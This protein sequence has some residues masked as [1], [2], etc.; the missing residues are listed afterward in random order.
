MGTR[1]QLFFLLFIIIRIKAIFSFHVLNK[2]LH[3]IK[4]FETYGLS[5]GMHICAVKFIKR[6]VIK[7]TFFSNNFLSVYLFFK[8]DLTYFISIRFQI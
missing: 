8:F 3:S 6:L 7:L 4:N 1:V 5:R 2:L